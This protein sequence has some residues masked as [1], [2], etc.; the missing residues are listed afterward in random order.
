MFTSNGHDE[1][2]SFQF[3][4]TASLEHNSNNSGGSSSDD[5]Q[6]D[7]LKSIDQPAAKRKPVRFQLCFATHFCT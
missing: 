3:S 1:A 2:N 7:G 6:E 5:E 4:P